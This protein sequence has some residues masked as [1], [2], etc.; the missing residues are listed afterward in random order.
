M[1]RRFAAHAG[2][3]LSL[4]LIV[5]DGLSKVPLVQGDGFG[6]VQPALDEVH[7]GFQ[8]RFDGRG[9]RETGEGYQ[10]Q[11][12]GQ[13]Q[14]QRQQQGKAHGNVSGGRDIE[15]ARRTQALKSDASQIAI[16]K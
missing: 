13:D 14:D 9:R 1:L 12:H 11:A 6:N 2:D 3:D 4:A 16:G 8:P 15:C 7:Q 10:A 5:L